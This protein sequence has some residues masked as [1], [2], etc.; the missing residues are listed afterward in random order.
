MLKILLHLK[1]NVIPVL[2]ELCQYYG[3]QI[4]ILKIKI[5]NSQS[6]L[7]ISTRVFSSEALLKDLVYRLKAKNV[8]EVKQAISETFLDLM[9][10][11]VIFL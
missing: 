6:T 10:K 4:F 7:C 3:K 1:K 11:Y 2:Y 8:L 9:Q 5:I